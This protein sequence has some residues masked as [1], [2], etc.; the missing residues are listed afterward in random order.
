MNSTLTGRY[1]LRILPEMPPL[2]LVL[3]Q[4]QINTP[5]SLDIREEI[6]ATGGFRESWRAMANVWNWPVGVPRGGDFNV[7]NRG[8][9]AVRKVK[10]NGS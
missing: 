3:G 2:S 1:R 9:A 7:R 10:L 6:W 8:T 5:Q 4:C